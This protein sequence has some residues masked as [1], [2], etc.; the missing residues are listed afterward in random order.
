MEGASMISVISAEKHLSGPCS[1][2]RLDGKAFA[3]A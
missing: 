1:S 2:R 3:I